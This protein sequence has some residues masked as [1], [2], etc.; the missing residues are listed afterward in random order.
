MRTLNSSAGHRELLAACD[1]LLTIQRD[2]NR[3]PQR[4]RKW[5]FSKEGHADSFIVARALQKLLVPKVRTGNR[6]H[7]K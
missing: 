2:I 1:R 3:L 7:E 5:F 4:V 6:P